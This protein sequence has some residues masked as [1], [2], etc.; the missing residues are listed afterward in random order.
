MNKIEINQTLV[1]KILDRARESPYGL[2][3]PEVSI[4]IKHYTPD[5]DGLALILVNNFHSKYDLVSVFAAAMKE[6]TT[7]N[8]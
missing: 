6:L 2:G 1:N 8:K 3:E 5:I 7:N 4:E